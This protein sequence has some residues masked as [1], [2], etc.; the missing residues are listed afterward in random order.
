MEKK[1][2]IGQYRFTNLHALGIP[3]VDV[4]GANFHLAD[5]DEMIGV[6]RN[7]TSFIFRPNSRADTMY[8]AMVT[9]VLFN[10]TDSGAIESSKRT[11]D[12]TV[13]R[14]ESYDSALTIEQ[15]KSLKYKGVPIADLFKIS[16]ATFSR[17]V[18]MLPS[19]KKAVPNIV[20]IKI[21]ISKVNFEKLQLSYLTM[22]H[23]DGVELIQFE[24]EQLVG[25][26][27]GIRNYVI[28]SRILETF[29][30]DQE[31]VL[32]N[33]NVCLT[34]LNAKA[35]RIQLSKEELETR[36]H[37]E[38]LSR[39][40]AM[41]YVFSELERA[42]IT[43]KPLIPGSDELKRIYENALKFRPA[44]LLHGKKQVYWDLPSYLHIVMRHIETYQV[45]SFIGKTVL[46]YELEDLKD[47]IE[48]VLG[49]VHKEI[50]LHFLG[51]AN[52]FVRSG[53]M[54]ILFNGD[55]FIVRID[56]D[57]RLAQFY[58]PE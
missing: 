11:S 52:P 43:A 27:L 54:A 55:R 25:L 50:E 36:T 1:G 35:A 58:I 51:T 57:G 10:S 29:G 19:G 42:K 47:L 44:I 2:L 45:G 39:I 53:S 40:L 13:V 23:N 15:R 4:E 12:P 22:K 3:G 20:S 34:A 8:G 30:F 49:R 28:D 9:G 24:K 16:Y 56:P 38:V 41:G 6:D 33:T 14:I 31:S 37:C 26:I 18:E 17:E 5:L 7:M 32:K 48:K 46:P 21:D